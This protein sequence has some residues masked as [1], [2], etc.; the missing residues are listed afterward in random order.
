MSRIITQQ[1]TSRGKGGLK[2][3]MQSQQAR[4]HVDN[5]PSVIGKILNNKI[6]AEKLYEIRKYRFHVCTCVRSCVVKSRIL[7]ESSDDD[8]NHEIMM[9]RTISTELVAIIANNNNDYDYDDDNDNG[10]I[11]ETFRKGSQVR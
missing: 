6:A 9:M 3:K 7:V 4:E 10:K 11:G 5:E 8:D 1:L 2:W